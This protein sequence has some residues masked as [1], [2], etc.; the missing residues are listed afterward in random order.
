MSWVIQRTAPLEPA[1]FWGRQDRWVLR[2]PITKPGE[3]AAFRVP[4]LAARFE[5]WDCA[6]DIAEW[7]RMHEGRFTWGTV[8]AVVTEPGA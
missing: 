8:I 5:C 7:L 2:G 4:K 1:S 3:I 6:F